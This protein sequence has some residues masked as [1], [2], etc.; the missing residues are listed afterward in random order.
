MSF[1]LETYAAAV[2]GTSPLVRHMKVPGLADALAERLRVGEFGRPEATPYME[3]YA[4][5]WWD[6]H[7]DTSAGFVIDCLAC[8]NDTAW[9]ATRA[10]FLVWLLCDEVRH[11][12]SEQLIAEACQAVCWRAGQSGASVINL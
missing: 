6:E 2:A 10:V 9:L 8:T 5:E 12:S 11:A 7:G 4:W 3:T 1:A